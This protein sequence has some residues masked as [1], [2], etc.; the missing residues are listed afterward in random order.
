MQNESD[1]LSL[2][3]PSYDVK[4]YIEKVDNKHLFSV[5]GALLSE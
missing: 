4:G 5:G 2:D 3:T 1:M